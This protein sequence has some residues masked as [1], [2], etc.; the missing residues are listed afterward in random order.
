M[1]GVLTLI[2]ALSQKRAATREAAFKGL[3]EVIREE[4]WSEEMEDKAVELATLIIAAIKKGSAKEVALA[5]DLA[6]LLFLS[7]QESCQE[8]YDTVSN[9]CLTCV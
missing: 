2:D 7:L 9:V 5:A 3:Q 4:V 6:S 1:V 8:V